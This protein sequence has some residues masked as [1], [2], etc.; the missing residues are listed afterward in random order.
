[1]RTPPFLRGAALFFLKEEAGRE[2]GYGTKKPFN[3]PKLYRLPIEQR[4]SSKNKAGDDGCYYAGESHDQR[5][6]GSIALSQSFTQRSKVNPGIQA[7]HRMS[8]QVGMTVCSADIAEAQ[9]K[10][11][12][13]PP[14]LTHLLCVLSRC[15]FLPR[16]YRWF[17][18]LLPFLIIRCQMC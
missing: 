3:T 10:K 2:H 9:P 18:E 4:S 16:S 12:V 1:M 14:P 6:Q 7:G 11:N 15:R 13:R 8:G 17:P 5:H